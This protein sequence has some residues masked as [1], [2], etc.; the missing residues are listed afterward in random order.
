MVKIKCKKFLKSVNKAK[1]QA[2]IISERGIKMISDE[3]LIRLVLNKEED[4]ITYLV[5]RYKTPLYTFTLNLCKDKYEAEELFQDTWVKVFTNLEQYKEKNFKNWIISICLNLYRDKYRKKKRWLN[6][7]TDFFKD[8]TEKDNTLNN[9]KEDSSIDDVMVATENSQILKTCLNELN[10]DYRIPV[11]LYY[12]EEKTYQ[13]I[14]E[15]LNIPIGTV[16]SRLN[17]AKK[18]LK[19]E[20][21]ARNFE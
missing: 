17:S 15:I 16:K 11:I 20:M 14:S 21:E 7:V 4:A 3:Q 6:K 19:I 10:D 2:L 12:F 5:E 1:T 8:T 18:K 13:E 9:V